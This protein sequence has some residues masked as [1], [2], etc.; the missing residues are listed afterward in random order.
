MY[1]VLALDLDGTVLTQDHTIHPE[2]RQA[3][4]AATKQCHVM[5]VTGRH[6]TA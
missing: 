5:I 6:H 4:Q 3:I 2:V 1:K